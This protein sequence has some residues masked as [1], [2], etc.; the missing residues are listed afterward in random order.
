MSGALQTTN[1]LTEQQVTLIKDT[2]AKGASNDELALFINQ[3]NRT[4]LD[5]FSRQ[6]YMIPRS[7]KTPNGYQKKMDIM[8]S[9]DGFRVI[10]ARSQEYRGQV[11]PF[12]CGKDGEWKD[13]WLSNEPPVAAK[14]GVLRVGFKEPLFAVARFDAYAQMV[15]GS[16]SFMWAKMCDLMIA[17]CAEALA[18]RKAFPHELSG[19]YTTDEMAQA[20]DIQEPVVETKQIPVMK[21]IETPVRKLLIEDDEAIARLTGNGKTPHRDQIELENKL[22]TY[23]INFGRKYKGR[24]FHEIAQDELEAY[25]DWLKNSTAFAKSNGEIKSFVEI[26]EVYLNSCDSVDPDSYKDER[27]V[28]KMNERPVAEYDNPERKEPN[29][30]G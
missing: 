10:A 23:T 14:V 22:A 8:V 17:K 15:N 7:V 2:I 26:A 29:G 12:W 21:Q 11:G 18:L 28:D 4:G 13:V 24:K 20:Q 5:P 1:G 25:V 9:I 30:W 16:P 3:C 6:I 19:L 27:A